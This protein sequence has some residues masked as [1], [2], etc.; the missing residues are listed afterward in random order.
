M[1]IHCANCRQA[2]PDE[3]TPYRCTRCGG[4]FDYSENFPFDPERVELD[5]PGIWRY[6]HSFGLPEDTQPISLGEGGTPLVWGKAFGRDVAFKC[7]HQNPTGSFKDRGS[8]LIAAALRQRGVQIAVEDSSGNA[9]ASFSAYAAWAGMQARIFVPDSASGPKRDQIEAYGA[10]LVRIMGPRSNAT[11]AALQAVDHPSEGSAEYESLPAYASHAYL[12]FNLPGYATLAYELVEQIGQSPGS[13]VLPVGQG[14]LLLGIL[15]GFGTMLASGHIQ[16][17][18]HMVGVQARA[19]APLWAVYSYGR[20][21][22]SWVAEG[23]TLA[24]GIRVL[25]PL[26][27]DALL[28]SLAAA[29]GELTAVDEEEISEGHKQLARLGLYVEPTSAVVWGA[30]AQLAGSLA[31]PIVAVL[32]GSG[33]KATGSTGLG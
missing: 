27:G 10:Q 12:P 5:Q 31:E 1:T 19:C 3:G 20:D 32:T 8:A 25:Y 9:G 16:Q 30:L 33:L 21:G 15:R 29:Q 22:L 4:L 23:S 26:R 7:E 18:P 14:G 17:M 28:S 2:Y 11:K 13:V 24:E 6:R